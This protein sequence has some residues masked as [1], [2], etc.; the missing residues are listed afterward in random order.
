MLNNVSPSSS[1]HI[2]MTRR[3]K[4]VVA[5]FAMIGDSLVSMKNKKSS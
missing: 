5:S 3:F 1:S 2:G 4:D